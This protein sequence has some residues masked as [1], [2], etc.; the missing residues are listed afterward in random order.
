MDNLTYTQNLMIDGASEA[1]GNRHY[2]KG[3]ISSTSMNSQAFHIS[4]ETLQN[5]AEQANAG[6]PIH[7]NHNTYEFQVGMSTQAEMNGH[8]NKVNSEFYILSGLDDVHSDDVI[9]RMD[10]GAVNGLSIG[11]LGGDFYC[12]LCEDALMEF[13]DDGYWFVRMC[14]NGHK[15]GRMVKEGKKSKLVTAEVR[16]KVK[17]QEYSVVN[18]PADPS[19][20]MIKKLQ[21][22]LGC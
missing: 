13:R 3:T 18:K 11:F 6:V 10:D 2:Y 4:K 20:K 19:A 14:E 22:V 1:Q 21:S 9:T 5:I 17:L 8:G 12:D 7:F 15:L 16:G